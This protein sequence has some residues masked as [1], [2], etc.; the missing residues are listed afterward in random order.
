MAWPWPTSA[1]ESLVPVRDPAWDLAWGL[2]LGTWP[3]QRAGNT[4]FEFNLNCYRV[5]GQNT[6]LATRCSRRITQRRRPLVRQVGL[7]LDNE[8]H[9]GAARCGCLAGE[10]GGKPCGRAYRRG[11]RRPDRHLRRQVPGSAHLG[12]DGDHRRPLRLGLHHRARRH[13]PRQD[14]RDLACGARLPR[15]LGH[16]TTRATPS[17]IPKPPTCCTRC[18]PRR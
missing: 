11:P 13:P 18:I 8:V 14:L 12:R 10:H 16:R 1:S 4:R 5:S 17:P 9:D 15:G 3:V 6:D 2:Q 7:G